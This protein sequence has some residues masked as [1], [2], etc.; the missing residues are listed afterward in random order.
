MALSTL[1]AFLQDT[2]PADTGGTQNTVRIVAGLLAL[3]LVVIIIMRR[4]GGKKKDE[5]EF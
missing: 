5:E 1:F 4:K 3:A 2:P